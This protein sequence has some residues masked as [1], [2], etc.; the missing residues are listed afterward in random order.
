[1]RVVRMKVGF[2]EVGLGNPNPWYGGVRILRA[3]TQGREGSGRQYAVLG[4]GITHRS[5]SLAPWFKTPAF[6]L[7]V[8]F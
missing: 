3:D 2:D 1:M 4:V 6:P 5:P 8:L 7:R